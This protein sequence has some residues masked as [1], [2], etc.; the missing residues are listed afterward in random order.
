[1]CKFAKPMIKKDDELSFQKK[2]ALEIAYDLGYLP[3]TIRKIA[4]ATKPVE[5]SMAL[6][7]ARKTGEIGS[8][9]WWEGDIA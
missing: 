2:E 1:M 6:S 7:N 9:S 3:A 4:K 5:I 8:W